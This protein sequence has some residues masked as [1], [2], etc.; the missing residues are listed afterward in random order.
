MVN[1]VVVILVIFVV[2]LAI[3]N[4]VAYQIW[5]EQVEE[6]SWY[7]ND[8]AVA[9]FPNMVSFIIIFNTLI[10]L[11]L[12]VSL[13]VCTLRV[14]FLALFYGNLVFAMSFGGACFGHVPSLEHEVC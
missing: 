6:D 3:F 13:E 10:P 12:Y 1:K 5:Q 11:S 2:A 8:A 7:L 4:T 14:R 9:F